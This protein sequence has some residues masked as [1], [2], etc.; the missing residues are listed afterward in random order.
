MF[1][2]EP[3]RFRESEDRVRRFA[4]GIRQVLNRKKRTVNVIVSVDEEQLHAGN[5]AERPRLFTVF[6]KELS[7]FV[8]SFSA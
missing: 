7:G 2:H 4:S 3:E 5:V 8:S 1:N 6:S